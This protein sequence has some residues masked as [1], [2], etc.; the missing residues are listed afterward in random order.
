MRVAQV[1][2]QV[3]QR[4]E[5]RTKGKSRSKFEYKILH[6]F[7]AENHVRDRP[8]RKTISP[9][10]ANSITHVELVDIPRRRRN[11]RG[12]LQAENKTP[13]TRR[14]AMAMWLIEQRE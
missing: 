14:L 10:P 5:L 7:V 3:R 12:D 8:L 9:F 4:H 13:K 2:A 1:L 11:K 6:S